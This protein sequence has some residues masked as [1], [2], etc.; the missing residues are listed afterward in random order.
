VKELRERARTEPVT[1]LYGACD[2]YH[3]NAVVLAELLRE[4]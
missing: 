4:G 2:P 3:N 1:V